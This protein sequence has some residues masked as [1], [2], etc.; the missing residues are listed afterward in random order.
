KEALP[1]ARVRALAIEYGTFAMP[2]TLG[3][4]IADNWLHLKG[5]PAS[6]LG[7]RIKA[8]IRRAFYPDEDDWKEMVALRAHQIMRRAMRCV[9]EA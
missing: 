3:A 5:D 4:L 1:E 6:P 2:A 8:E 7:K 9:A